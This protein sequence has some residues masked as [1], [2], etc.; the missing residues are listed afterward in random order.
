MKRLTTTIFL[1]L[2]TLLLGATQAFAHGGQYRGPGGAVPPNQRQPTD[3]QPP[4]PPP[5]SGTPVTKPPTTGGPP[6]PTSG[7][8]TPDPVG[9]PTTTEPPMGATR[10][11]GRGSLGYETWPFWYHNNKA[12]IE[13][14]KHALYARSTTDNPMTEVGGGNLSNRS[15]ATQG[16]RSLVK[17]TVIPAL[18]WAMD[19]DNAG[20]AD[21]ESAAYI[22]LAKMTEDPEHIELIKKGLDLDRKHSLVIRES[23]AIAL[24]L[25][26]RSEKADQL[27]AVE[28][29]RTR[30]FLFDVFENDRYQART[31]GFA[32][33]AI[34]LLGDQP[35][36]SGSY[37]G[38]SA[39]T[40]RLFSLLDAPYKNYDLQIGLLMAVGLQPKDSISTAQRD[41]L[42]RCVNKGRMYRKDVPAIT[43]SYAA[44]TLG[45]VG[46]ARDLMTLQRVLNS[47]RIR[48][49]NIK[50][51]AAIGIGQLAR[52]VSGEERAEIAQTLLRS[53]PRVKDA[54][55]KNFVVM[56][57]SDLV[58]MDVKQDRTDVLG[59]TRV[60]RYLL[61]T[62]EDGRYTER[63][64]AA[65]ALAR[66]GAAIG[67]ETTLEL[68]GE[69]R[70]DSITVLQ[71]GLM[72]KALD[73]RNRAAFAAS[74]GMLGD[75][76][77]IGNLTAL[78]ADR[79]EDKELR[80]YSALALGLIGDA[81]KSVLRPIR[82]AL[83]ERSSAE[84]ALHTSTALGLLKD[85]QGVPI[86]LKEL[87]L[88]KSQYVKGQIVL[89]LARIG[90]ARAIEP[91]VALLKDKNDQQ[92]TR[93]LACAG[94][95]VIGDLEW[96]PSFSRIRL[97]VNYRASTDL[98][99][100][101]LSL[102]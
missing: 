92:L 24:G 51:S 8:V 50:R 74:L 68:Y 16:T 79:T 57:L 72:S 96:L 89:A 63:P 30:A 77:S 97:D 70:S 11:G 84:L 98:I 102:I 9:P 42:R 86:L 33:L 67:E 36:G 101:V 52:S 53:L 58:V 95:G 82:A 23:A 49:V 41:I 21:T 13:N 94:L 27:D 88:A 20:G 81:K 43:R 22:A 7:P 99:N 35:S 60:G 18:L 76:G 5:P 38:H 69:F 12:V 73:K 91:M 40:H 1:S 31:R 56:S 28:L 32:A 71:K 93:A 37:E 61:Q 55:A 75:R 34:G 65:L 47:K 39:T 83:K 25:L 2:L 17:S 85:R 4:P 90:D 46:V 87:S 54:S 59:G 64:F 44:L 48:D 78:V 10:R 19:P 26:R 3:P 80:G 62:A 15:D 66:I 45:R 14:L 6:Q 29:D 100:E